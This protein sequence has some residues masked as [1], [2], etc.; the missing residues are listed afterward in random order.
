MT[1][2]NV[3]QTANF[4]VSFND[5]LV[6]AQPVALSVGLPVEKISNKFL[7][8]CTCRKRYRLYPPRADT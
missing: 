7:A 8:H 2:Q 5:A 3:G 4:S 1:L 6:R